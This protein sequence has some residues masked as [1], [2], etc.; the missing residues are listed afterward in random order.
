M[1]EPAMGAAA[2]PEPRV[3]A[4][5]SAASAAS[6]ACVEVDKGPGGGS[7]RSE[8]STSCRAVNSA[9]PPWSKLLAEEAGEII[10]YESH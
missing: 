4:R 8:L 6:A 2:T 7:R 5:R 10:T 9:L 1:T 3:A